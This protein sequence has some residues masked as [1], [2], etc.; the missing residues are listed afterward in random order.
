MREIIRQK[1]VDSM[2][3]PPPALT[4][5]DVRLPTVPGKVKAVIGPRRAGKTTFLWQVIT[6]ALA[7]GV[8][9]DGLLY[10]NFEDERLGDLRADRL[11]PGFVKQ[12]GVAPAALQRRCLAAKFLVSLAQGHE[13]T[14]QGIEG[15]RSRVGG[16][17]RRIP[18]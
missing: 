9:R 15:R 13:R 10:F 1:I 11:H 16:T 2:A 17:G 12:D 8:S 4:P 6:Q 18:G 14:G 7:G 5:R 3:T